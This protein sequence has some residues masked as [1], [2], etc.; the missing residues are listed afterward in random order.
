MRIRTIKPEFWSHPIMGRQSDQV[1]IMAIGLLN[2]ADDE[3]YFYA[4]PSLVRSALRPFDDDST[5]ARACLEK[6]SEIGYITVVESSKHGPIGQIVSFL[7]HQRIDR[8][9]KSTIK[10]LTYS[11]ND[12]RTIDDQ[13]AGEGKGKEGKG[14]EQGKERNTHPLTPSKG[15]ETE[16][17]NGVCVS[18]NRNGNGQ[19]DQPPSKLRTPSAH[20][21][22]LEAH[23]CFAH[24][25]R[26]ADA[27]VIAQV[28]E[29]LQSYSVEQ[30]RSVYRWMS[31]T[32]RFKPRSADTLTSPA[33]FQQWMAE[34]HK[35]ERLDYVP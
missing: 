16:N 8:P 2:F 20:V 9:N 23:A 18:E 32:G 7:D 6:L 25:P 27:R 30:I 1:K 12:R 22:A 28:A 14:R 17:G 33:K 5:I 21:L 35:P 3:G 29:L 4:D 11:T 34:A 24:P 10:E 13:S 19:H 31:Q 15:E 26:Q